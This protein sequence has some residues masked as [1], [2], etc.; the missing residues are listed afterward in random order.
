VKRLIAVGSLLFIVACGGSIHPKPPKPP[1]PI[2]PPA[3]G[4]VDGQMVLLRSGV[5]IVSQNGTPFDFRGAKDCCFTENGEPDPIWPLGSKERSA[6]LKTE[7]N[8][9]FLSSRIGPWRAIPDDGAQIRALGGG[10]LEVNGKADLKQWN[11][12]FWDYNDQLASDAAAHGQYIEEGVYDGWAAKGN[13]NAGGNATY[14]PYK[15]EN[16][17]Q[18]EDHCNFLFDPVQEAW[19]RQVVD[20]LGRHGNVTWETCN[21]CSLAAG[22]TVGWEEKVIA[23]IR[24]EETRKGYP[25]HLIASN[26]QT[27][28]PGADWNESHTEGEPARPTDKI[29]G[30]NEYNPEPPM[31]GAKVIDN[32]CASRSSGT[33]YWLWRHG[34][35]LDQWLVAL[36]GVK[37]GC[38]AVGCSIPSTEV[39]MIAFKGDNEHPPVCCRPGSG[40]Q[41][42]ARNA[43]VDDAEA[44]VR[45]MH[46]ELFAADGSLKDWPSDGT[47]QAAF[48]V[49]YLTLVSDYFRSKGACASAWEDSVAWGWKGDGYGE[50]NHVLFF[51]NGTVIDGRNAWRY[52]WKFWE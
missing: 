8:I 39:P 17:V 37:A 41:I 20:V 15:P 36:H 3:S 25:H 43:F 2:P 48:A 7:G 1:T 51:K 6:W 27:N 32:Y 33:Y 5:A 26:A 42:D 24:D 18:G 31:T 45:T 23:T 46:P 29:T 44:S 30:V 52:T 50:E 49:T 4:P 9:N 28:V 34:M 38:T 11:Q 35:S 21:E 47:Q 22:W 16:N 19:V 10:Y 40:R 12:K 13:C 14:H